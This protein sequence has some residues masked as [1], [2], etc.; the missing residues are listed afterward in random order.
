MP[1][2]A[3]KGWTAAHEAFLRNCAKNG[4]D[5]RT[6]VILLEAEFPKLGKIAESFVKAKM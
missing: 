4:E 5:A 1:V 3:P 6:I 2:A